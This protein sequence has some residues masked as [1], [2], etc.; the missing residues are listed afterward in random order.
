MV[1]EK[2]NRAIYFN[3]IILTYLLLITL[4]TGSG[5]LAFGHGLGDL[6]YLIISVILSSTQLLIL[7][8]LIRKKS[9]PFHEIQY[10]YI[11]S[12]FLIA[13]LYLTWKFTF[14]RGPEYIWNGN[15][16]Y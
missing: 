3:L 12:F 13:A 8:I 5:K 14:G 15:I 11:G 9:N 16:F 2:M 4:L 7:A 10:Y 6:I 1:K